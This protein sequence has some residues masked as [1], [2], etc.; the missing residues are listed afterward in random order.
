MQPQLALIAPLISGSLSRGLKTLWSPKAGFA[1]RAGLHHWEACVCVIW[2]SA[3][4]LWYPMGG[5]L[6]RIN[7]T[8]QVVDGVWASQIP[9]GGW[10]WLCEPWLSVSAT[11]LSALVA[12]GDYAQLS[13]RIM[14]LEAGVYDVPIIVTDSGNPP[15]YNTSIIKVK[16]CPCDENG[17]CTTIGAVAAAGLG[18]GAIIAILIC[19]IILLS[20]YCRGWHHWGMSHFPPSSHLSH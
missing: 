16:V 19:I 5:N 12:P 17:D 18:T 13:L 8:E 6:R 11:H 15:L 3:P 7:T 20:E 10:A 9:R 2:G 14:Y 1:F 4:H